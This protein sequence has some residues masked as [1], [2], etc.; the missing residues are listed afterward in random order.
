[1]KQVEQVY[2][3]LN[4]ISAS[5]VIDSPSSY[6]IMVRAHNEGKNEVLLGA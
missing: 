1:M 2:V 5:I 3:P 6:T 4:E